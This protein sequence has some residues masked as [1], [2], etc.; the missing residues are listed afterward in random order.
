MWTSSATSS[1]VWRIFAE[2]VLKN[3]EIDPMSS[4]VRKM[5]TEF[6]LKDVDIFRNI[7]R[8]VENIYEVCFKKC[9]N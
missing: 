3:A 7:L 1:E 6:V 9:G 5:S 4:K 2:F 8:G